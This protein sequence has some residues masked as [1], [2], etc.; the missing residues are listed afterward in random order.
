MEAPKLPSIF[1]QNRPRAFGYKPRYYDARKER[2]EEMKK[3]YKDEGTESKSREALREQ[4]QNEWRGHRARANTASNYRLIAI[5]GFLF[6]IAY[7]LL[8]YFKFF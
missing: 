2:I 4:L 5:L 8:S 1:K 3:K 7:Y 6:V